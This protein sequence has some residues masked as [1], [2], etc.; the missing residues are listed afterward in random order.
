MQLQVAVNAPSDGAVN[1]RNFEGEVAGSDG[2]DKAGS[3]KAGT[4]KAGSDGNF[5]GE[6]GFWEQAGS[7]LGA[8]WG[9]W[10]RR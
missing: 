10:K 9:R 1:T 5:D 7:K 4:D 2:S 6:E 8:S 3:D